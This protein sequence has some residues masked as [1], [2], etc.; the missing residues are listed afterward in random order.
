MDFAFFF[1]KITRIIF[2]TT[3]NLYLI[4]EKFDLFGKYVFKLRS[5]QSDV[6]NEDFEN[7]VLN[8]NLLRSP[9]LKKTEEEKLG[10]KTF[11]VFL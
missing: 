10:T 2:L 9:S 8:E 3:L 6:I 4:D 11:K 1:C 7:P 5:A